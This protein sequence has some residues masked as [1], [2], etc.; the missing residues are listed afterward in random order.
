MKQAVALGPSAPAPRGVES[1]TPAL[2]APATVEA[3]KPVA[4]QTPSPGE[5]AATA[6]APAVLQPAR[7][8]PTPAPAKSA[9]SAPVQRPDKVKVKAG[10]TLA[11]IAKQ[12]GT[13]VAA[14]M[15]ENNMVTERVKPG[16]VVRLPKK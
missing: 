11:D 6:K 13:S 14:I 8:A 15:M 16:Q 1:A 3:P 7:P 5:P 12:W 4:L 2:P 9:S 10:E